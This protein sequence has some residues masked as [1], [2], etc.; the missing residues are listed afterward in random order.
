[1]TSAFSEALPQILRRLRESRPLVELHVQEIDTHH[2]RDALLR[3]ELDVA[4]AP[5]PPADQEPRQMVPAEDA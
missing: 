2:G 3:R 4:P 1:V 5:A